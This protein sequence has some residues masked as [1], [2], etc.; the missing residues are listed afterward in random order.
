MLWP[1]NVCEAPPA[2]GPGT[3]AIDCVAVLGTLGKMPPTQRIPTSSMPYSG[4]PR[5]KQF[6]QLDDVELGQLCDFE[7]C[8]IGNGYRRA[9]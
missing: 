1:K 7:R 4:A 5:D 3:Y 8:L 2:K 9:C 6:A